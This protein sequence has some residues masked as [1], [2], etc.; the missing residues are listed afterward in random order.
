MV[1][2]KHQQVAVEPGPFT[3]TLD[4]EFSR[5]LV[6]TLILE[7]GLLWLRLPRP[8]LPAWRAQLRWLSILK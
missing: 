6:V 8:C 7:I 3:E 2:V 4:M 5:G 1:H